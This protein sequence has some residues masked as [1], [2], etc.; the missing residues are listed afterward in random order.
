M[1]VKT[2]VALPGLAIDF[3]E[4]LKKNSPPL[5]WIVEAVDVCPE[6]PAPLPL[7]GGVVLVVPGAC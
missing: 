4:S 2:N 6:G 7:T 3:V 1:F 5:T